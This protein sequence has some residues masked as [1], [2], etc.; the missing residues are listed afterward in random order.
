MKTNNNNGSVVE[1]G[2]ELAYMIWDADSR[3]ELDHLRDVFGSCMKIR[4]EQ[5][6]VIEQ[7]KLDTDLRVK[8]VL[9]ED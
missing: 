1:R 6:R 2:H 3:E 9:L 8:Y 7:L 4:R 5:F